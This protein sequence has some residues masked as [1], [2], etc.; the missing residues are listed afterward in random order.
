[1]VPIYKYYTPILSDKHLYFVKE[2]AAIFSCETK[3]K[4][5]SGKFPVSMVKKWLDKRE[6]ENKDPLLYYE[7]SYGLSRVY[8]HGEEYIRELIIEVDRVRQGKRVDYTIEDTTF[9]L[10]RPSHWEES[11]EL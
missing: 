1:M 6:R 3:L 2:L 4:S 8:L 9:H 7:T 11:E 5:A 10:R